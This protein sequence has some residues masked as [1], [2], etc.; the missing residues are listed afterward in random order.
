[1]LVLALATYAMVCGP[2]A[3]QNFPSRPIK[4][5]L[6]YGA[7]GGV[8]A[9]LRIIVQRVGEVSGNQTVVENRT[10]AGGTVGSMSVKQSPPD[11][12]T[13]LTGDHATL[14]ANVT[15]MKDL[16]YD[17]M[18]DF[19]PLTMLYTSQTTLLVSPALPVKSAKELVE[20]ARTR[21]GGLSYA[22]Q[23]VG[24]GGHLVGSMFAKAAGV[25]MTHIPYRSGADARSDLLTGRVDF[26][27]N[28]YAAFRG[29]VEAGTI[30]ALAIADD[31]RLP[32]APTVPTM[33]EAG[34]PT[35]ELKTW[36][37][38]VGPAGI[39]PDVVQKLHRMFASV[40]DSPDTKEKLAQQGFNAHSSTPDEFAAQIKRDIAKFA[41][42]VR[43][44]GA[45][46][47]R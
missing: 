44:A 45:T 47:D 34:F 38:L 15:L 43:E 21:P 46:A 17:P 27:F 35:V 23:G 9:I 3:A 2:V 33:A 28:N 29:D 25:P 18:K 14:A 32:I 30:K 31:V 8:D 7:G 1:M 37:G 36:F 26:L 13:L 42:L 19:Q 10:G 41:I 5:V 4:V 39:P 6:P 16:P 12:Y 20:L 40:V 24:S 22:S 11:G